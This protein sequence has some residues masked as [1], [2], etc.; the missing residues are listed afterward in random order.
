MKRQNAI[1]IAWCC[2]L[3]WNPVDACA[4]PSATTL[5]ADV[6]MTSLV[7][8]FEV[9]ELPKPGRAEVNGRVS[10]LV[11][12]NLWIPLRNGTLLGEGAKVWI[13]PSARLVVRFSGSTAVDLG[14]TLH[15]RW[16]VFE[17]DAPEQHDT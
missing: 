7:I 10:V 8:T 5:F 3:G 14:P 15:E 17:T 12:A 16:V 4:D 13:A 2:V 11:G 6:E 1:C 9:F